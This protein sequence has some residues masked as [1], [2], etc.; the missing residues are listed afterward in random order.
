MTG[1][2]QVQGYYPQIANN[3]REMITVGV[4]TSA[5]TNQ[6]CINPRLNVAPSE[7]TA[8]FCLLLFTVVVR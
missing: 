4:G 3:Y 1:N 7:F 6:I 2:E 5:Q 8:D